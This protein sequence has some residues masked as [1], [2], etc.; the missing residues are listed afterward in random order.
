MVLNNVLALFSTAAG[1]WHKQARARLRAEGINYFDP[2][3]TLPWSVEL[4]D[5]HVTGDKCVIFVITRESVF[6]PQGW[7]QLSARLPGQRLFYVVEDLPPGTDT[8]SPEA[9]L[10]QRLR[11]Q[12]E[13][14][15]ILFATVDDA[16]NA[17]IPVMKA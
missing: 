2:L 17:A 4:E 12:A 5:Q 3:E 11:Q 7:A 9:V 6:V 14:A 13:A 10:R 16:L 8:G 1:N 15:G